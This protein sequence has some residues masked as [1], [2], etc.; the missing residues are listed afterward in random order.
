MTDCGGVWL[1]MATGDHISDVV[2]E[3]Y[4]K[5]QTNEDFQKTKNW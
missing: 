1:Y 3:S 5:K 2:G 4:T